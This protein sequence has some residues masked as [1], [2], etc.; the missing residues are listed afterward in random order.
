MTITQTTAETG[1]TLTGADLDEAHRRL[2]QREAHPP[3]R[4]DNG[5][6]W[7]PADKWAAKCCN[8]V[9]SPSRDY[10]WSLMLHCRTRRHLERLAQTPEGEQTIRRICRV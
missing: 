7:Y 3:G 4:T 1:H 2:Q 8:S 5:G 9:R 6:R 10:P